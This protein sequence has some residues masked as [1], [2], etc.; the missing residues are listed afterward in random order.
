MSCADRN[1]QNIIPSFSIS[2]KQGSLILLQ[3]GNDELTELVNNA[4]SKAA[5]YYETWYADA[6]ATAGIETSYDDAGN[7]ITE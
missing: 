1:K 3:K 4:L 7:P 5:M 2:V 6:R